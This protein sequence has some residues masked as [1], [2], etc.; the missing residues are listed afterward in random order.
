MFFFFNL[1][2]C[3]AQKVEV[4]IPD[5]RQEIMRYNL[6]YSIFNVGEAYI[7]FK[8]NENCDGAWLNAEA[9]SSG[10]L[11]FI[12]DVHYKFESCM[13]TLTGLPS[14]ASRIIRED[15]FENLNEVQYFHKLRAD[16]SIIYSLETDSVVV[17]K[18]I[19]D[20]LTGFY[21]FRANNITD[22]IQEGHIDTVTTYFIDEVWD[23]II[24][25]AGE[26]TINTKYGPVKCYK[27]MPVTQVGRYFKT[28]DDLSIWVTA[29]G[30]HIPV[31]L[32]VELKLGSFIAEL[33]SYYSPDTSSP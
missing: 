10:L 31:K 6:K 22:N 18:N 24:R 16:S 29:T 27:Y 20:I 25:F 23:L 17:P 13:D 1:S 14:V 28:E 21:H 3:F 30:K 26:E 11:K 8:T 33:E 19:L 2:V 7:E 32:Q 9:R 5:F 12:K 4:I 15:D